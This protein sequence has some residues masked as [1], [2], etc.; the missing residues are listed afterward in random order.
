MLKGF[1]AAVRDAARM[2]AK[3][4]TATKKKPEQASVRSGDPWHSDLERRAEIN[5]CSD[6]RRGW[7]PRRPGWLP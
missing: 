5:A 2:P 6:E 1:I 4:S 7:I 3:P